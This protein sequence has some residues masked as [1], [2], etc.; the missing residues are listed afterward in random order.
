VFYVDLCCAMRDFQLSFWPYILVKLD[1]AHLMF[2][3]TDCLS[4]R[5]PFFK[6]FA[7][8]LKDNIFS[9]VVGE[10][11]SLKLPENELGQ[12]LLNTINEWR[13]KAPTLITQ[14]ALS[15]MNL[16][17]KK[18]VNSE[19]EGVYGRDCISHVDLETVCA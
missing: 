18:H 10:V 4:S 17:V 14:S 19:G 2:R 11:L 8:S 16:Q 5:D 6:G 7:G 9:C 1:I 12:R 13:R 3:I 15:A